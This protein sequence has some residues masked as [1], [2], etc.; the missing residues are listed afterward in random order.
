[1]LKD[2]TPDYLLSFSVEGYI[3]WQNNGDKPCVL[4]SYIEGKNKTINPFIR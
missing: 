4:K 1:M 2:E 3:G